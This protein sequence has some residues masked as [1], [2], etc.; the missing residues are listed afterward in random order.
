MQYEHKLCQDGVNIDCNMMCALRHQ[1]GCKY[2]HR[3]LFGET[4]RYPLVV[5]ALGHKLCQDGCKSV[6]S[7][8]DTSLVRRYVIHWWSMH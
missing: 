1:G 8:A 3:H 2:V 5:D 4:V 6:N 7:S